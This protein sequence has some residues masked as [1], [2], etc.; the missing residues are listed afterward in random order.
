MTQDQSSRP[1]PGADERSVVE[2]MIRDPGSKHWENLN[3]FVKQRVRV[4]ARNIPIDHHEEIIQEIMLKVAR[5]LPDFEFRCALKSWLTTIITHSIINMHR[6]LKKENKYFVS[7]GEVSDEDD[8]ESGMLP[9]SKAKP[10]KKVKT[11]EEE[12]IDKEDLRR[13]YELVEE[14]V[15]T[16]ANPLRNAQIIRMVLEEGYTYKEAAKAVGCNSPVV[17]YVVREVQRYVRERMKPK[18]S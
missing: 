7:L 10:G 2:E 17:G 11:L 4:Q 12:Y 13:A 1:W 16:H 8:H 14:Y 9:I 18:Q 5:L 15:S 3:E 6:R